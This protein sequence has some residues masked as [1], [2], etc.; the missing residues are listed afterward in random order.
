MH[1]KA[2]EIKSEKS[3]FGY[4]KNPARTSVT[5]APML[6][7]IFCASVIWISSDNSS[8]KKWSYIDQI[9]CSLITGQCNHSANTKFRLSIQIR[10]ISLTRVWWKLTRIQ[11]C[12]FWSGKIWLSIR[13]LPCLRCCSYGGPCW[14]LLWRPLLCS[15]CCFWIR[16][17]FWRPCN[18]LPTLC[19]FYWRCTIFLSTSDHWIQRSSYRRSF[20]M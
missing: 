2:H 9:L 20:W 3:G 4:L 10:D 14:S 5:N 7:I 18:S 11:N 8:R 16:P 19:R 12:V 17:S 15:K 6:G 1:D 13:R